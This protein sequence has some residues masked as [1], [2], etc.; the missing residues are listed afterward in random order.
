MVATDSV[1][2]IGARRD[3][4]WRGW[5]VRY[6]YVRSPRQNQQTR[7]MIFLHGFGAS[8]GHWRY[9][10][11]E[12]SQYHTVYALDLLGF[13]ASEKAIASYNVSLWVDL[14]YEFWQTFIQ[15][16]AI[17]V[18]NS[19]GSL[20]SVV[21]AAEHRE[22]AAGV[23]MISLPD[24]GVQTEA[25]PPWMLPLVETVQNV[26]ASPLVLRSLFYWVR[27]PSLVRRWVKLAYSNPEAITEDF[28]EMLATP[29][30]DR[31]AA[32]AFAT[33]FKAVGSVRFGPSLKEVFP[34]LKIPMLLI[35]GKQD[36]LIP[37]KFAQPQRYLELNPKLN[38]IEIEQAGHCPH[39]ECPDRVN[40]EI[41]T[42]IASFL[43]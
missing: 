30:Q 41:L 36:R 39:H 3:W 9:N 23:V 11:A 7:P 13:G 15:E 25:I 26:I 27:R 24:P 20:I 19:T 2:G 14:V 4:I 32:R 1:K 12:L 31:G 40:Q 10:L 8:L 16:P 6:T 29:A 33:L 28:I 42:W 35:W 34:N 37:M 18:G 22:M 21:A 17:L 43:Q 5:R 38:L